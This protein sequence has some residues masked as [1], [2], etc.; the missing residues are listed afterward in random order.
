MSEIDPSGR[1]RPHLRFPHGLRGSRAI[2]GMAGV[3]CERISR[4]RDLT[5]G[6]GER[7]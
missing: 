1:Q 2:Q 5:T 6:V 4:L 7:S 3:C